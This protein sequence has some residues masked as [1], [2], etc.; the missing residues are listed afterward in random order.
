MIDLKYLQN[1]FDEASAKLQKK[2]IDTANP[3]KLK[4]LFKSLKEANCEIG[5]RKNREEK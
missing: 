1:N 3:E 2:G 5:R 4:S